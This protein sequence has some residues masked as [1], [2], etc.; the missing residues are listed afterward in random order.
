MRSSNCFHKSRSVKVSCLRQRGFSLIEVLVTMLILTFGLLGVAGLLVNG[1]SNSAAAESHAKATLLAADIADRMRANIPFAVS[2]TSPYNTN[3][4]KSDTQ[5]WDEA[6]PTDLTAIANVD[7]KEWMDSIAAQL[8][9]GKGRVVV[10]DT[11]RKI[12]IS[13]RWSSCLGT[14]SGDEKNACENNNI[15]TGHLYKTF[16]TELRL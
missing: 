6:V 1:I 15:S 11:Q 14:Q 3:Q 10:L 16:T 12:M 2:A 4:S 13:I 7:K 8:P 5:D 9:E